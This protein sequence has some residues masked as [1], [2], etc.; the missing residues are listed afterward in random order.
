M[1]MEQ[2]IMYAI[3]LTDLIDDHTDFD[4]EAHAFDKQ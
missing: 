1:P 3:G 4:M 2:A